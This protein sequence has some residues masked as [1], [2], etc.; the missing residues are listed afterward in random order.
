MKKFSLNK[1]ILL[2]SLSAIILPGCITQQKC[3]ER[4]PCIESTDTIVRDSVQTIVRD[5]VL[6]VPSDSSALQALLECDKEQVRLKQIIAYTTGKYVEIPIIRIKDNV[7]YVECKADS[8]RIAWTWYERN[9]FKYVKT[10][11]QAVQ[12]RYQLT[13]W[14]SF[15][16]VS[17]YILWGII[18]LAIIVIVLKFLV[19]INIPFLR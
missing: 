19:K 5:S 6:I 11:T 7:I 4:F 18:L 3:S 17:G 10:M 8:L 12:V 1:T 2:L 14:Q 15:L 9:R 13:K 16:Y